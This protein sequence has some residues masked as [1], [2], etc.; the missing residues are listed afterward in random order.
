MGVTPC[1]GVWI[2]IALRLSFTFIVTP[3]AGVWIEMVRPYQA[4]LY[5]LVTPCAGVWIE[6]PS[7]GTSSNP[8]FCHSLCG[9]VD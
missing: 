6:I 5:T 8:R 4:K 9:S 3:C 7:S 2:E 1:A